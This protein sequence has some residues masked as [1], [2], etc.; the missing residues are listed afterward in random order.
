VPK[1]IAKSDD[2]YQISRVFIIYQKRGPKLLGS[3]A[4]N[5]SRVNSKND[6]FGIKIT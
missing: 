4:A 5:I 1:K 3:K 2:N 6:G